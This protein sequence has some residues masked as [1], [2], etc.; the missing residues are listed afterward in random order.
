M[1]ISSENLH[2]QT[3]SETAE[4]T[5][6]VL[7]VRNKVSVRKL[8]SDPAIVRPGTEWAFTAISLHSGSNRQFKASG[9]AI[10]RRDFKSAPHKSSVP[11]LG[12]LC[13]GGLLGGH[14]LLPGEADTE[15]PQ[16]V[17]V[18]GLDIDVALDE[19]LPLFDHRPQLVHGQ[20]HPMEVG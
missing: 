6:G 8:T 14:V 9:N 13:V 19:R 4:P 11:N 10:Q 5:K 7:L 18:C 3:G 1:E 12:S 16:G 15:G 17:A 2:S 20:A